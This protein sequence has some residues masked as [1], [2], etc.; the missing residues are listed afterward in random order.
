VVAQGA[1]NELNATRRLGKNLVGGESIGDILVDGSRD[2]EPLVISDPQEVA[3]AIDE[4]P[5]L[6]VLSSF[7]TERFELTNA[8]E[9][10]TKESDRI[11]ALAMNLERLGVEC[12]QDPAGLSVTGRGSVL[13]DRSRWSAM[14]ITAS[15]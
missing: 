5:M 14:T 13:Q 3:I 7:A 12:H 15:Q 9:L 1:L 11:E 6:G 10:R 2:M 8:A 4:L